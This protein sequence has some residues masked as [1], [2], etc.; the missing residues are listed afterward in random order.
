MSKKSNSMSCRFGLIILLLLIFPSYDYFP[1]SYAIDLDDVRTE[2]Y[3]TF[4]A[5]VEAEDRGGN[6]VSLVDELNSIVQLLESASEDE[7]S[8]LLNR[9]LSASRD[10]ERIG[11][12]GESAG[13][14]QLYVSIMILLFTGLMILL[15]WTLLPNLYWRLWLRSKRGWVVAS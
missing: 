4:E 5:V 13:L 10:A 9:V 1:R 12:V 3:S 7:Y 8:E 14:N 2:L 6:V 11:S 15:V